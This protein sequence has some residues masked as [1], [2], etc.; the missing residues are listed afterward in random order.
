V[1]KKKILIGCLLFRELTG[2]E[3]YV[4]ELAKGLIDFNY[5]VSILSPNIGGE[6][7]T[8]AKKLGIKVYDFNSLP[9]KESF[10][11]IHCQHYPITEVLI[12][13]FPTTK[14]ICTIHSEVNSLENP[15]QHFT[16]FKYI[17]IRPEIKE[18]IVR[19]F[20]INPNMVEVI[21]NPIDDKRF[22]LENTTDGKYVL[23]VGTLDFLREKTI[24]DLVEYTKEIGKDFWVVGK[25][26]SN[27]L[28]KLIQYP[29][30]KYYE[31]T[32]NIETFVKNCSETGGI[33]LGRTTIE[34]WMCGKPGWIYDV[35]SNGNI[36]GKKL[37]QVP[38]D[39]E[40]FYKSNVLQQIINEYKKI[41]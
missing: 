36:L 9:K 20:G 28:N 5:E 41:I 31:S 1:K 8:M 37:F 32:F 13:L 16:I 14:K 29:H 40:K 6:L 35:D 3:M 10:D 21:Y 2:S 33:L 26:H 11:L 38:N 34:G 19:N 7:T 4:F 25:N 17:A 22:N 12:K 18:H 23:F 30:V 24:F 27:Y 15:I 39:V